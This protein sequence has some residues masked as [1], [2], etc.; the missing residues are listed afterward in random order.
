VRASGELTW[1]EYAYFSFT[2]LSTTGFADTAPRTSLARAIIMAEQFTG[3]MYVAL[4]IAHLTS[5]AAARKMR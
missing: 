3:V 1:Y 2:T 5:L 4:V